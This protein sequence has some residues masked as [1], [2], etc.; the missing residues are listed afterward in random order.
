MIYRI[1]V[2]TKAP[3]YPDI[4]GAGILAEIHDLGITTVSS[5][6]VVKVY[7]LEGILSQKQLDILVNE[8]LVEK[9]WQDF[10]I[11]TPLITSKKSSEVEIA[12]KLGVMDTEVESITKAACDLGIGGLAAVGTG[13]KYIFSGNMS[14]ND[15][16]FVTEKILM[17][18]IVDRI[19]IGLE[20]TLLIKNSRTK[21]QII[22]IRSMND[23]ELIALSNNKLW[24]SLAEMQEI[25]HYFHQK[26]RDPTDVEIELFAQTW[27]EHCSHKT[28]N[29]KLII[30]GKKKPSLMSRLKKATTK[31]NKPWCLSVFTDNAGV[32]EF[33]ENYGI[34]G[35]VETHNS[36]SAI[37]PYGGAMTGSGGVFRDIMGC[38]LGARVLVSTD[39]FCFAPP[40]ISTHKIPAGCIH[41]LRML[42]EVVRGVRNY[43]NR[44]GIP[45]N[46][47]SVHF[48]PDYRA[49]PSIIVG[50]YG[51]VPKKFVHKKK[52]RSGDLIITVGG[53]TGRDGIHGVTFASGSM[54]QDTEKTSSSAVQIGN[55]VEEKR[56]FDAILACRDKGLLRF[57][58]DCGGGGY[59]SAI[60]EVAQ[61]TGADVHLDRIPLKYPGLASWEIW[62]SES[63]ERMILIVDPKHGAQVQ[64]ICKSYNVEANMLGKIT[65]TK[66]LRLYYDG[67]IECDISNAFLHDGCPTI[68]KE[69]SYVPSSYTE[70]TLKEPT[71]Y[72]LVL[73]K[74]LATWDICSKESIV[75]QYDHEVQGTSVVKPFT[76]EG[77]DAPND[78]S[79]V[80]PILGSN[81]GMIVGHG[82]IPSY[83]KI[84]PYWGAA[85]AIDEA[86]RNVVCVGANP[87]RIALIDNFIWPTPEEKELGDLDRAVDACYN[88]ATH[89]GM[90]FV[91]GKDSLS[92]TYVGALG[93][94]IKIPGTLCISAFAA[95]DDSYKSITAPFK[96]VGSAI[97]II[98]TTS[99]EL[100]GSTYYSLY[101]K[102]GASVP[103]HDPKAALKLYKKL[104]KAIRK[105]LVISAHD[106]SEG[107]MAVA[108]AEM[109][110]GGLGAR[111][112]L[113]NVSTSESKPMRPDH[114]LF[115]ESNSRIIGEVPANKKALFEKLFGTLPHSCIGEVIK[116][117]H[118]SISHKKNIII[119]ES[120]VSLK[121]AWKKP[122]KQ[123]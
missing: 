111:I 26:K 60:G 43:G 25:Q 13:K 78:A 121:T 38:G 22:P 106:A 53:K 113:D 61:K 120:V 67:K 116:S 114:I 51:I 93:E 30:D 27:S 70:P 3:L 57:V 98:G 90:P 10:S 58:Q 100:G 74:L 7:K 16:Q 15:L 49:K 108:I 18:A 99:Q 48:H 91:S 8:L 1:E 47:G 104:Y 34:C 68:T 63:Q 17:N 19:V 45:T 28:F 117:P 97:Y 110:F 112:K 23:K 56:T 14:K 83:G 89:M 81:K 84:D 35:K 55:A 88:T 42:K 71:N 6:R 102:L 36:P 79:V 50:A 29:A 94:I 11:N 80:A 95:T 41:P 107:G 44:M 115:S 123:L 87:E 122:M 75:R 76:G 37:E 32:I 86:V 12:R 24:L 31:M 65:N 64:S 59:S 39:I 118:L 52:L 85:A 77:N 21:T 4:E 82:L 103:K 46:N 33:D 105:G 66:R 73:K 96:Q 72:N 20:K 92:S 119:N 5:V 2:A 101:N 69:G 54:T 40:D 109:C 62:I 9:L